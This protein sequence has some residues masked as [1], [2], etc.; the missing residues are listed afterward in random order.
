MKNYLVATLL[1]LSLFVSPAMASDDGQTQPRLSHGAAQT[2]NT[3]I[4]IINTNGVGNI[5]GIQCR[6]INN[7]GGTINIFVDGGSAQPLAMTAGHYPEDPTGEHFTGWIPM[8]VRFLSSI[9]VQ[10]VKGP[11]LGQMACSISWGLD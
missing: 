9:R 3:A 1:V 7:A 8:N 6:F 11:T 4:D 5:K 10:L 2:A